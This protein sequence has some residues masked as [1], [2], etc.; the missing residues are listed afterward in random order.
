MRVAEVDA[1]ALRRVIPSGDVTEAGGAQLELVAVEIRE[2]GG[3]TTLVARTRQPV[4]PV[5]SFADVA[6]SDSG[7]FRDARHA[8]G[9]RSTGPPGGPQSPRLTAPHNGGGK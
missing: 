3:I 1:G 5:G 7:T 6:V 8:S 2:D 9:G 4:G